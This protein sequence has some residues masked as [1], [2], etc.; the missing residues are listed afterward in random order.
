[1]NRCSSAKA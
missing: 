1:I